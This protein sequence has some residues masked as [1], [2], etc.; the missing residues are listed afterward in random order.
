MILGV[1]YYPE[2]WPQARWE[3]DARLMQ[4]AGI[5]RVR[6]AEF[7]WHRLEPR[8]GHF[9]FDWLREAI[10]ILG[11]REIRTILG[12]PTPTYPAWLHD[13][14]PDLHQV[15]SSGQVKEW[16]QRQ[17]ACK[18]HLGYRAYA[19]RIVERMTAA[20]GDN[21]A[22]VGW[23]TDNEFGCHGTARC[24]CANC[25]RAFRVWLRRR[26]NN[27]IGALNEA[28]GTVFWSH[29][30]DDFD[31]IWP[32]MDTA[33]RTANDGAN[34]GLVLDFYRFSSDVQ[35]DFHREQAEIIRRNSPGR[36]ITHNLM[37]LFPHI[38]Y[39]RLA[40]D[41]DI[42]SWD[43]YPFSANG[44]N[45]PPAPLAHDL[46]RG[47][48]QKNVWVMEQGSGA[49][50]WGSYPATPQPGQMRLWAYQAVARGA[51][52]ISF[53]RWRSC[54][55]GREQYWHGILYHH[56]IPQR[57]YDEAKQ[58]GAEFKALAAELDG[59]EVRAEVGIVYDYDSL[60]ALE[61]Q[62]NT[63]DGFDYRGMAGGWDEALARLGVPAD[64]VGI[65]ADLARYKVLIAPSVHVCPP[66]TAERL[67]A[68][69]RNGGALVL[70]P[71]SG[72]KDAEG[73]IVDALLPG[74]LREVAGCYVEEYDA[75]S[76][77][78]GLE[79][80]VRC[81]AG[82][83]YRSHGLADVLVPEGDAEATHT[84]ADHYYTGKPAVVRH[85]VGKGCC[86]YVGTVMAGDGLAGLLR[87]GVLPQAGVA[88]LPELP[89]SIEVSWRSKGDRRYAFYLNHSSAA[90]IVSLVKPGLE[91]LTQ[92][93]VEGSLELPGFGVA[94]VKEA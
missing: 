58:L 26:F 81:P 47:L 63:G 39:F 33:D 83:L 30:Y 12:T 46:M 5:T 93:G 80:H 52:M 49:G 56:G 53:F 74:L 1:A 44:A 6:L 77:V 43:N 21:P 20:L 37:G 45:R 10:E 16:G 90:V 11:R 7:A 72:V 82:H 75:F 42:V 65:D 54:R 57:R 91:L 23:Q 24:H 79:M 8:D 68:F 70:G 61:T 38:D 29:E 55:W 51:D 88:T 76:Q 17:D 35:I 64:G 22:V 15:K 62:P 78:A 28:W 3:T 13:I 48:K 66:A 84:Y 4:E 92:A 89:E 31:Q 67:A 85:K 36:P 86:F 60:W 32:P 9:D 19:R 14:Y 41:L 27:Q 18:N 50:G 69:V 40:A 59:S 34:P 87:H 2:H 71:R 25:V 94:I 73:A